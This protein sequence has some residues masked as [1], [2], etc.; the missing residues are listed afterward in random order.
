MLSLGLVQTY[1]FVK[2]V[3]AIVMVS[4]LWIWQ[5]NKLKCVVILHNSR[6]ATN[7]NLKQ[8]SSKLS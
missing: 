1:V 5:N 6:C 2:G 3:H 8:I 4:V 7:K